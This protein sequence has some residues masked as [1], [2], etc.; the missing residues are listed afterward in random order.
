M[1]EFIDYGNLEDLA[2]FL[3]GEILHEYVIKYIEE[4][5]NEDISGLYPFLGNVSLGLLKNYYVEH[6]M[7]DELNDL[8]DFI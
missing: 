5:S 1:K 3:D 4:E 2:P 6:K 8:F 7:V